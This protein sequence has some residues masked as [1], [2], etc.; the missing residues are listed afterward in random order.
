MPL[1]LTHTIFFWSTAPEGPEPTHTIF[2]LQIYHYTS[3]KIFF[4]REGFLCPRLASNYV[5][6]N[7]LEPLIFLPLPSEDMG[8]RC[9]PPHLI[10]ALLKTGPKAYQL[11]HKPK[12]INVRLGVWLSG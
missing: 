2:I 4:L 1:I 3:I 7:N 10:Y 11:S 12:I 5:S 8:Y 6:E 9:V